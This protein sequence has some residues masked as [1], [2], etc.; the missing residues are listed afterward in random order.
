MKR[1][2][3]VRVVPPARPAGSPPKVVSLAARRKARPSGSIHRRGRRGRLTG[4]LGRSP[5]DV[6]QLADAPASEAG[7]NAHEGST[8]SVRIILCLRSSAEEQRAST[9]GAEV[10]PLSEACTRHR[11]RAARRAAANR[12]T[13][14]RVR[15]VSLTNDNG[16]RSE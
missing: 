2:Y 8:P 16:R 12:E 4:R 13:A 7:G 14:V 5:A 10:R 3:L 6:A 15:P 9:P 11:G 1:L